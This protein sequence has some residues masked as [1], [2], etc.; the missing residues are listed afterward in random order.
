[1]NQL[2]PT[3]DEIGHGYRVLSKNQVR[4]VNGVI[5]L[6]SGQPGPRLYVGTCTH[7]NE[8]ITA[9]LVV[10]LL[11]GLAGGGIELIRGSV[12]IAVNNLLAASQNKREADGD[13]NMNR[14]PP[15]I[16]DGRLRTSKMPA[17]LRMRELINAGLL[18]VTHGFDAHTIPTPADQCKIHI[19]G[20]TDFAKEIGIRDYLTHITEH[21]QDANGVGTLAFGNYIGGVEND[22]PVIEVEGGGPHDE[23]R[24]INGLVN[25]LL[26]VLGRLDMVD[27]NLITREEGEQREYE[28]TDY[29]IA[30]A[31][32]R[33]E[34]E[35]DNFARVKRGQLIAHD[36]TD[37]G[38]PPFFAPHAGHIVFPP[39]FETFGKDGDS[40][41]IS[42]PVRRTMQQFVRAK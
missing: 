2:L 25:G 24:I 38:R 3:P 37:S 6:K 40:W 13:L 19:K 27:E 10:P 28:I 22:I 8:K 36:T 29:Y 16:W 9:G 17:V 41:W 5:E 23:Q 39:T 34:K 30:Q 11:K 26:A 42:K 14:L 1:M 12:V 4:G 35:F 33:P 7:G 20:S 18:D 31:G 15:D 21:Q 32:F